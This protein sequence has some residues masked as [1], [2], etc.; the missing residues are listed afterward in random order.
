MLK[1]KKTKT[2]EKL[3][4]FKNKTKPELIY[5]IME[6]VKS[7]FKIKDYHHGICYFHCE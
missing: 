6:T 1:R 4:I 5:K 7:S 2:K 3:V